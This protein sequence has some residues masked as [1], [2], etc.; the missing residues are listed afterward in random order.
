MLY[1]ISYIILNF[2]SFFKSVF[3]KYISRFTD[4]TKSISNIV[5][6]IVP[7]GTEK[8]NYDF[9]L[10]SKKSIKNRNGNIFAVVL[11]HIDKTE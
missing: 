4:V 1:V 11:G 2:S 10:T 3:F 5:I 7:G 8:K 6:Y 9:A